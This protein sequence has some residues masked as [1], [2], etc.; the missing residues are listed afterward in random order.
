MWPWIKKLFTDE[1]AFVGLMRGSLG[2]LGAAQMSGQLD[3]IWELPPIVGVAGI[4]AALAIR[5]S[6]HGKGKDK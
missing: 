2:G 6:S 1:T 4:A 3:G 5:S